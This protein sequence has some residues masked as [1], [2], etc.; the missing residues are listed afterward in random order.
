MQQGAKG[1]VSVRPLLRG[2]SHVAAFTVM[3]AAGP[4]LVAGARADARLYVA[5]HAASLTALF[6]VSAL[7]HRKWWRPAARA[8]MRRLDHATIFLLIAGTYTGVGGLIL[9]PGRRWLLVPVWIGA[10]AG[11]GV[12][13]AWPERRRLAAGSAVGLGWLAVFA[14]PL[15]V[16]ALD[17]G[18]LALLVGG[19]LLYSGGAVAYA[20]KKPRLVPHVFGYHEVFH[21][22]VIGAAVAHTVL[23]ARLAV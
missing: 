8:V 18:Q 4:L 7:Y 14:A 3:L 21:L 11:A 6:G 17:R 22:A 19:G 16:H 13:L 2:W 20:V 12:Q 10:L 23:V 9:E 15:L 1:S 5:A